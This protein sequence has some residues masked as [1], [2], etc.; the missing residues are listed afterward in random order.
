MSDFDVIS[1]TDAAWA[2]AEHTAI[3]ANI[4]FRKDANAH[5]FRAMGNDGW[6]ALVLPALTLAVPTTAAIAQVLSRSLA[7]VR[8]QPFIDAVR[9]KGVSR[10]R[11]LLAHMLPNAAVPLLTMVGIITGNLLAG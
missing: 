9:A 10:A 8:S 5:P 4:Q 3:D 6:R 2:N 1:I 11:L 7:A